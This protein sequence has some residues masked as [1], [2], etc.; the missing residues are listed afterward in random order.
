MDE[1][2]RKL[3]EKF[4]KSHIYCTIATCTSSIP[5]AAVVMYASEGLDIYFFTGKS[6][7]KLKNIKQ[8]PNIAVVVEGKRFLFFPQAIEIQGR[9]EILSGKDEEIAKKLY[10]SRMKPEFIAAKKLALRREITWIKV[11][12]EK[13]FTYGI[14]TKLLEIEPE[15]QFRRVV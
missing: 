1:K 6:T 14:G 15:E 4:L 11:T 7:K 13:I 3:A 2:T 8:N 12:P 5:H 9:A 10:F